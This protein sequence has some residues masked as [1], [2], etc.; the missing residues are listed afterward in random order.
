MAKWGIRVNAIV[1]S[2]VMTSLYEKWINKFDHPEQKL[3]EITSKIPLGKRMTTKEE[4]AFMAVFLMSD[5]ASLQILL[6]HVDFFTGQFFQ[7]QHR[8]NAI[9]PDFIGRHAPFHF[10]KFVPGPDVEIESF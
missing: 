5:K 4:I 2:E 7:S 6:G 10:E 8:P 3:N 1:P 9:P